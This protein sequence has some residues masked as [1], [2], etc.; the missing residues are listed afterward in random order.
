[1]NIQSASQ[2]TGLPP[3]TIRYYE[4]IGLVSPKRAEN[5]Y[6][7][8]DEQDLGAL[9][10]LS[11]ARGLGFKLEQCR[12]LLALQTDPTRRSADVK[13]IAQERLKDLELTAQRIEIMRGE[14][15]QMIQACPGNDDPS[16]AIIR[17]LSSNT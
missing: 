1:M 17:G 13:R 8:F 11:S 3:K 14:L 6:R 10:F 2:A 7:H 12:Q 4:D 16:C 15:N 9:R 5:G